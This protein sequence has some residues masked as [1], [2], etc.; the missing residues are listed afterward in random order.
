MTSPAGYVIGQL[1]CGLFVKLLF[2]LSRVKRGL[3]S[4]DGCPANELKVLYRIV[5]LIIRCCP[6]FDNAS[7]ASTS[8]LRKWGRVE[9]AFRPLAPKPTQPHR[10]ITSKVLTSNVCFTILNCQQSSVSTIIILEANALLSLKC[11][12]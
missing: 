9:S 1:P 12:V 4:K 7:P 5:G 10:L 11:L 8:G 6:F 2:C 3:G